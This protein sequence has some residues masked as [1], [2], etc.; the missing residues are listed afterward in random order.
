MR[1]HG[2]DTQGYKYKKPQVSK[3]KY[4]SFFFLFWFQ[5]RATN[6]IDNQLKSGASKHT[7][8]YLI[9]NRVVF[10]YSG[11]GACLNSKFVLKLLKNVTGS[12]MHTA[13]FHFL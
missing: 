8:K 5:V 10:M 12:T 4:I 1:R 2:D 11:E 9:Y 6:N 3:S 13:R 7:D